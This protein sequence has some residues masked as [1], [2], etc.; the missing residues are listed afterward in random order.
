MINKYVSKK[1][2]LRRQWMLML[3]AVFISLYVIVSF[4]MVSYIKKFYYDNEYSRSVQLSDKLTALFENNELTFTKQ[5]LTTFF[6]QEQQMSIPLSFYFKTEGIDIRLIDDKDRVVYETMPM[7]YMLFHK[8][9]LNSVSTIKHKQ[10]DGITV[11]KPIYSRQTNTLKGYIQLLFSLQNYHQ[12]V[13]EIHQTYFYVTIIAIVLCLLV[14]NA[15]AYLFFR[16]I[17]HMTEV[18]ALIKKDALSKQRMQ[19][20]KRRK[21]ELMELSLGFNELLDTMDLYINQQKQFVEDVSHELRTPV[22]IVEGHLKLLNRWGK[23]DPAVLEESL[24]ASLLE[25]NRMKTLVQEMLDLSRAE[26]VSIHY[27]DDLTEVSGVIEQ[28]HQNFQIIYPDFTFTLDNDIHSETKEIWVGIARHHFEQILIILLDNAVKYSTTQ[29]LIHLSIS[30]TIANV[31]IT[32]QDFGEGIDTENINKIF[33]RF[34]RVDKARSRHKG[35]NGLGLS[36]AK[37][38]IEGYRGNISVES[39]VGNGSIFRIEFPII[40]DYAKI[41]QEKRKVKQSQLMN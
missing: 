20:S 37:E 22:A 4:S 12:R 8:K 38:L 18:M 1:P 23:N 27:A 33:G 36:I 41:V 7:P 17:K 15:L 2:S 24:H 6:E 3:S 16:P 9:D 29:K 19:L 14:A 39:V 13:R 5:E 26:Q 11:I 10:I 28:V 21:D 25:I 32:V 35:G 30:N 40:T 34:Y 31:Q